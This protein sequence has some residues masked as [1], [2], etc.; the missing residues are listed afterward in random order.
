MADLLGRRNGVALIATHSPV[1]LQEV[2]ASCVWLLNRSGRAARA[3]RPPLETFGENVSV[4]TR[5]VFRLE[6][7]ST[8]FHTVISRAAESGISYEEVLHRFGQQLGAEA[9]A[10]AR[11]LVLERSRRDEQA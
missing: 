6:L 5:E 8:G 7:T 10:V 11:A 2:P 1:V 9:R 4:L 3:E